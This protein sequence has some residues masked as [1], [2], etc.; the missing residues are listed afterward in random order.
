MDASSVDKEG[1][2]TF[3]DETAN[4]VYF[5][6]QIGL[7]GIRCVTLRYILVICFGKHSSGQQLT[8]QQVSFSLLALF[9]SIDK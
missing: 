8:W 7:V 3:F 6:N 5:H 2:S 4:D 1:F 9:L